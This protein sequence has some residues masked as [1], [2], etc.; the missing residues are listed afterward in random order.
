MIAPPAVLFLPAPDLAVTY[1]QSARLV[2]RTVCCARPYDMVNMND[3]VM[4]LQPSPVN[5]MKNFSEIVHTVLAPQGNILPPVWWL[6]LARIRN[7][8]EFMHYKLAP[9]PERRIRQCGL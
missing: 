9:Q 7:G 8:N 1:A 6:A 3:I 4:S 2:R 5:G